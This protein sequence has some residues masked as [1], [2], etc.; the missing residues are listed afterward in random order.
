MTTPPAQTPGGFSPRPPVPTRSSGWW[1]TV[2]S[3]VVTVLG[4]LDS[5]Q[6]IAL[7]PAK[8]GTVL[9]ALGAGAAAF[10]LVKHTDQST[11]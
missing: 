4:F 8:W 2:V 10:G 7:L 9:A 11:S 6:V 5:Q 3:T 1:T